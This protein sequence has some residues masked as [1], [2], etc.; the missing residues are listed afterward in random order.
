MMTHTRIRTLALL[1]GL[2]TML[3]GCGIIVRPEWSGGSWV[4]TAAETTAPAPVTTA[5]PY[6]APTRPDADAQAKAALNALPTT[7]FGGA[8]L[9]IA[10]ADGV[11]DPLFPPDGENEINRARLA[12][13]NAVT[14]RHGVSFIPADATVDAIFADTL[15]AQNAGLY[16]ADLLMLP[17][18]SVG[19]FTAA[20]L[21]RNLRN[22]PFWTEGEDPSARI[23]AAVW[24]DLGEAMTVHNDLPA[25]FFNVELAKSLGYDLYA[26]VEEGNWTW[27]LYF[28]AAAK[29]TAAGAT[30][31][32]LSP[33]DGGRYLELCAFSSGAPLI[34]Q[35]DTAAVVAGSP[36]AVG[37]LDALDGLLRRIALGEDAYPTNPQND[38]EALQAFTVGKLLFCVAD[39]GYMDWIY[40]A[41]TAWGILPLP[42]LDGIIRTPV[43]GAAPVLCVTSAN[44]KFELTGLTIAALNAASTAV[45][46][47]A[48][49]TACHRDRL[50]DWQSAG[51][52]ERIANSA[53]YGSAT[54]FASAAPAVANA[55]LNALKDAPVSGASLAQIMTQRAQAANVAL[56]KLG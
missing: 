3:T 42:S 32:A 16:Y 5:P 28:E 9:I 15:A 22:L 49:V 29:A 34:E 25:V 50:R 40:D 18:S 45:I 33:A 41:S 56:G 52:V 38:I 48:Y 26:A 14:T 13:N 36:A 54:L 17:A 10:R 23:G 24:A 39:L 7:Q 11:S 4:T 27:D 6:T 1:L 53:V 21:L 20:G 30:G 37:A 46:T 55:T 51:M 31:H 2:A 35:T 44:N 43:G 8:S 47:D 19:R 12:R